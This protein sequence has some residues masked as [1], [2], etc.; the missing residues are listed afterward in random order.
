MGLGPS[1]H[2]SREEAIEALPTVEQE[3]LKGGVI[4]Q[5]GQFDDSRMAIS[6]AQTCM[7]YGGTVLNYC[8]VTATF[9]RRR[10]NKRSNCSGSGKR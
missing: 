10:F 7:D 5:D 6:L 1:M 9:K 4:Y 3:G 8:K 2:L